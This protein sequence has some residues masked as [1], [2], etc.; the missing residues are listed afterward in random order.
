VSPEGRG[1]PK[2]SE[3]PRAEGVYEV[4]HLEGTRALCVYAE[5]FSA[6]H[7]P[8]SVNDLGAAA[9]ITTRRG[10]RQGTLELPPFCSTVLQRPRTQR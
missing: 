4:V 6:G 1:K 8:V 5:D 10:R 3:E 2:P 7:A 9:A